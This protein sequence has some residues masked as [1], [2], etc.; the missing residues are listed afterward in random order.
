MVQPFSKSWLEIPYGYSL[1]AF[2]K[3]DSLTHQDLTL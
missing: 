2:K 1:T 3:S